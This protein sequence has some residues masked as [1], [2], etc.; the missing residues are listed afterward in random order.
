MLLERIIKITMQIAYMK[1]KGLDAVKLT[2]V[3]D[4]WTDQLLREE[5]LS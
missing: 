2:R 1:D 5:G 4:K 3:L